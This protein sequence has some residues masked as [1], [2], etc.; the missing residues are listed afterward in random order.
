MIRFLVKRFVPDY[1]N[2]SDERVRERYSVLSG[3]VGILCN[4]FLFLLKFITGF[5][6]NSIA[7]LS[8]GFNNL[9]DIGSSVVS[10]IGSKISNKRPDS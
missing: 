9:S 8:D 1:E 3:I 6:M 5:M 10:V 7:I 2:V 4:F